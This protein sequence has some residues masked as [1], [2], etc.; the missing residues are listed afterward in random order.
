[1]VEKIITDTENVEE[2]LKSIITYRSTVISNHGYNLKPI[3]TKRNDEYMLVLAG[4]Q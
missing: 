1:M 2:F 3:P 4:K